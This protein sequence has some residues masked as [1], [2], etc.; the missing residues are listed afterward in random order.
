MLTAVDK[1]ARCKNYYYSVN[2]SELPHS[3]RNLSQ[4]QEM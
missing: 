2:T 3:L 1:Q 4:L